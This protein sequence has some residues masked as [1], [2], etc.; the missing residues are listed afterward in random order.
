MAC[1]PFAPLGV[2]LT[3]IFIIGCAWTVVAYVLTVTGPLL[4]WKPWALWPLWMGPVIIITSPI[5]A[6]ALNIP[7]VPCIVLGMRRE[8]RER[9]H[10]EMIE[11]N[12]G[13]IRRADAAANHRNANSNNINN[14]APPRLVLP[15]NTLP[16][17]EAQAERGVDT[18]ITTDASPPAIESDD[19]KEK[20]SS[21][22]HTSEEPTPAEPT[23][24]ADPSPSTDTETPAD[25]S[26]TITITTPP[27]VHLGR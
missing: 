19:A 26:S 10:R 14:A 3:L 11:S 4:I 6:L 5:V 27:L 23:A 22:A 18:A 12:R 1:D 7:L 17:L 2:T 8:R 25:I 9:R 16:A 15:F 24:I 21:D 13:F 20:I